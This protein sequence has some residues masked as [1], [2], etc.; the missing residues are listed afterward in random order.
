MFEEIFEK[1]L[2]YLGNIK[3]FVENWLIIFLP[4]LFSIINFFALRKMLIDCKF[5]ED[6]WVLRTFTII[7][8]AYSLATISIA[9]IDFV[10]KLINR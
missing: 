1:I 4:F 3:K 9:I 5:N 10:N 6:G 2:E 7:S 8:L